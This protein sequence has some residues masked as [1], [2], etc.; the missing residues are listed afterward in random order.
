MK[1]IAA[2][3]EQVVLRARPQGVPRVSD[4]GF[5]TRPVPVPADGEFLIRAHFLSAD[6]LQRWR[7]QDSATYGQTI[8][9]GGMV[10]GRMVGQVVASRHPDWLEGEWAEGMLGWQGYAL[11][12]G[13]TSK[14]AYAP[15]VTRVDP[16]RGPVSTALGVLGM[17]GLTAY[18][19][20]LEICRPV[21][22]ETVVVSGAAGTVGALAGQIA[23]ILGCRVIGI[24]GGADKC[25]HVVEDLGFHAAV[26]YKG[27]DDLGAALRALCP[28]GVQAYYDNVGG[29]VADAVYPLLARRARVAVVGR[30]AQMTQPAPRADIQEYMISSRLR[31]EGF[32]VYDYEQRA[33]EA[34]E[35]IGDWLRSGQLRYVE[36]VHQGIRGA[37]QALIDVIEGRGRGK[38]VIAMDGAA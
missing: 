25:R 16:R 27:T 35:A 33:E 19:A 29:A 24:A 15:G 18:F 6:P 21:A 22:G 2:V 7:M 12:R 38:H 23:R 37:P 26:D 11:S 14:A 1:P 5:E 30:V 34:R 8:P 9:L 28:E 10:W 32:V 3:N 13:D 17:P 4:F 31:V 36:T 20:L